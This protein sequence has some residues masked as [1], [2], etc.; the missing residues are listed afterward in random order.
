MTQKLQ[1]TETSQAGREVRGL[2]DVVG[3]TS[4]H[5]IVL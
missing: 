5:Y 2:P 1:D 3:E 4:L